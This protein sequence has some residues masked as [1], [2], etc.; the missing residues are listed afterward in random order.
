M[1]KIFL[2]YQ[3]LIRSVAI[4]GVIVL[5]CL[6]GIVPAART[7]LGLVKNIRSTNSE[8]VGLNQ[9]IA[10]LSALDRDSLKQNLFELSSAI[11]IDK[12]PQTIFS[13]LEAL[14]AQ[15]GATLSDVTL[16][17]LGIATESAKTSQL[18]TSGARVVQF[19]AFIEG[20]I[21]ETKEFFRLAGSVRRLLGIRSFDMSVSQAGTVVTKV[22]MDGY[23]APLPRELGALRASMEPLSEHEE[24]VV[25]KIASFPNFT[26]TAGLPP[27]AIG[28]V[29]SD[30]FSP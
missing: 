30:L 22:E 27:A 4:L 25:R 26:R 9:K 8:I 12:S 15:A 2:D 1:R 29:K 16:S 18:H 28:P 23:F 14:S 3:S 6:F 10:V 7:T 5:G 21:L 20:T 19:S 11:P 17:G 13:T 24:A